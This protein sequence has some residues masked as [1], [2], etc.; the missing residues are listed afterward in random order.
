MRG[1]ISVSQTRVSLKL[2][3]HF[4]G[5]QVRAPGLGPIC[6][7][8]LE[9]KYLNGLYR[10]GGMQLYTTRGIGVIGV[11]VRFDSPLK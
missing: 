4:H 7:P 9:E 6:L 11:P 5:G 3:G 8:P 10:I 1:E 2:S